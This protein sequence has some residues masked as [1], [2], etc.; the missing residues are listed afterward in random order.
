[1]K[2]TPE[3]LKL[4][5]DSVGERTGWDFSRMRAERAP[6]PW[7]YP[8]VVRQFLPQTG[9]VLDIGTG[10]GEKFLALA[11]YFRKGIGTDISPAM[12]EQAQR[13]KTARRIANVD[14]V[15]MD[16]LS[17]G[18]P[19]AQFDAVLNRHCDVSVAEIARVLRPN[20]YF[21]TQQVSKALE[22]TPG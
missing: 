5:S 7:R 1:M 11:S 12:I 15:V 4:I 18:F 3:Q 19:D 13:N 16:G 2:F 9:Y 8:D 17:L 20:G 21:V 10:G 6:V 22:V 14:L